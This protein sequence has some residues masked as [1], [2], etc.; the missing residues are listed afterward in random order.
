VAELIDNA[1]DPDVNARELRIELKPFTVAGMYCF[2]FTDDGNGMNADS[3][4]KMLSFGFC[5]KDIYLNA[6]HKPV[7]HYGNG[8]KSG[9]MR[10]GKDAIVFTVKE[11][12]MSV[13]FLSQSYL[14][15]IQAETIL[16]PIVSWKRSDKSI[17][18]MHV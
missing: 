13:G 17:L 1:Y 15:A 6:A 8:F 11:E 2:T 16:V 3:L 5:D 12:T 9:S 4:H 14:A 7:G 18:S 10:L